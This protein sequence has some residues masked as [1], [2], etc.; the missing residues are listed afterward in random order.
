MA[1]PVNRIM[2]RHAAG[3]ACSVALNCKRIGCLFTPVLPTQ[4]NAFT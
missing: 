2:T 4:A 3:D 1:L